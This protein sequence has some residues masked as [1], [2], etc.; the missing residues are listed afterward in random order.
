MFGKIMNDKS[1]TISN[2]WWDRIAAQK[3]KVLHFEEHCE[4]LSDSDEK[5]CF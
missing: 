3:R 2:P 5:V 4:K 1:F